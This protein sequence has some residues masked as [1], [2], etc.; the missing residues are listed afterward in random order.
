[1]HASKLNRP[2]VKMNHATIRP[3]ASILE[4]WSPKLC[5]Y[6]WRTIDRF[7]ETLLKGLWSSFVVYIVEAS[8]LESSLS[9]D[10]MP[11]SIDQDG[12]AF[13]RQHDTS[14][15]LLRWSMVPSHDWIY[16][17]ITPFIELI[18]VPTR[19]QKLGVYICTPPHGTHFLY[20]ECTKVE[21]ET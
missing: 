6:I 16:F 7:C 14:L 10:I 1:M 13:G 19:Q 5:F 8:K 11:K 12:E 17:A 21:R 18:I 4:C 9:Y 20:L 2:Q 15:Y 3:F